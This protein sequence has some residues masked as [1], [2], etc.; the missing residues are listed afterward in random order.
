MKL[1]KLVSLGLATSMLASLALTGCGSE[2]GGGDSEAKG[3][4]YYLNFAPEDNLIDGHNAFSRGYSDLY[5]YLFGE[6]KHSK[7]EITGDGVYTTLHKDGDKIYA[8]SV[9]HTEND[10]RINI[11]AEGYKLSRIYY[12]SEDCVGSFDAS[13]L[14]FEKI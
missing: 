1:R 14:L 5:S 9:N 4:V 8:V 13:V 3:K 10:A 2:E 6:W 11:K 7:V 12:G